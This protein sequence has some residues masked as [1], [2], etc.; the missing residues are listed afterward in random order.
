MEKALQI[1]FRNLDRSDALEADIRQHAE[2]LEQFHEGIVGCRVVVEA[3]HRH[4]RHGNHYHVRVDVT[5]PGT[6]LV[7]KRD[8]DEHHAHADV[9]VAIHDVFDS[10]RHQLEELTRRRIGLRKAVD[11]SQP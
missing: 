3:R 8:P 11:R 4:H 5:V 1:T 2:K 10:M 9:Y 6:E 7:A